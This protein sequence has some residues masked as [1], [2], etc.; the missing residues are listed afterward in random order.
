MN[1]HLGGF[2]FSS[3]KKE[4]HRKEEDF[5]EARDMKLLMIKKASDVMGGKK[6]VATEEVAKMMAGNLTKLE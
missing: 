5:S 3:I 1:I 2:H 4:I 6:E